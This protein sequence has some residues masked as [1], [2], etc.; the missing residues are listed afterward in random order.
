M[1][2]REILLKKIRQRKAEIRAMPFQGR[3]FTGVGMFERLDRYKQL[4]N[5][6]A[7]LERAVQRLND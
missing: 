3:A 5:Q 4:R 7:L 1:P 2:T 6:I